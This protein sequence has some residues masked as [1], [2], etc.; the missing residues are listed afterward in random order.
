MMASTINIGIDLGTTNSLIAIA[1]EGSVEVFKNPVGH[2]ETL[3]SCVAF[4]NGRVIVGEKARELIEKDPVNVIQ[5][6][7]RKM[8]TDQRFFIEST[9][10]FVSPVELSAYVLKELKNFIYSGE[11]L[12]SAIITIPASFDTLQSNATKEAGY[13]AGIKEVVLLQEPIAASLAFVNKVADKDKLA[14]NWLV[15]DLGGGTFDAAIVEVGNEMRVLDHKGNNY[16]GGLDFDNLIIEKFVAPFL[17]LK[18]GYENVLGELKTAGSKLNRLYYILLHKAEEVK[19]ELS[20]SQSAEIEFD[21]ENS[22]GNLQTELIV[23]QR[24]EFEDLIREKIAQTIQIITDLLRNNGLAAEQIRQILLVGGSTYIPLVKKM[25]EEEAGIKVNNSIDP[26][27]AIAVGAAYFASSKIAAGGDDSVKVA[28]AA[29]NK[30][31]FEVRHSYNKHCSNAEE[32][33]VATIEGPVANH[34]Y[35]IIRNDGGF[36]TG[37]VPLK[38]KISA[39]LPLLAGN[40]NHFVFKI[41]D[42]GGDVVY[43]YPETISINQGTYSIYGQT[44]P[45]DICLEVDNINTNNTKLEIIFHKNALLPLKKTVVKTLSRTVTKGSAESVIINVFEGNRFSKPASCVALGYLRIGGEELT[46]NIYKGSDLELTFEISESRDIK[47]VAFCIS[48]TQ[49]FSNIFKPTERKINR[50]KL[51]MELTELKSRSQRE[52][53]DALSSENY[54]NADNLKRNDDEL[55]QMILELKRAPEGDVTD[56]VYQVEERKRYYSQ[57]FDEQN[58]FESAD[59]LKEEYIETRKYMEELLSERGTPRQKQQLQKIVADEAQILLS[60]SA[61]VVKAVIVDLE[62][63]IY[64]IR[65]NDPEYIIGRFMN[66]RNFPST[67]YKDYNR[68][69]KLFASGE[70]AFDERNYGELGGINQ[71]LVNNLI[72]ELLMK[73][74]YSNTGL[75]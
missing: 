31:A 71:A 75:K 14:G 43:T 28:E 22:A 58:Q 8:G 69:K 13:Q 23:I 59:Q 5:S 57:L 36:D 37:M 52:L 27:T 56:T 17:Q 60:P 53:S 64:E 7:K 20:V 1:K 16:L 34:F 26:T 42:S 38:D 48:T 19:K 47:V 2:K 73:T 6:F 70:K 74:D 49:E 21:Y 9:S 63:M 51:L 44:L 45:N 4:R 50:Q 65:S 68:A 61:H 67:S 15:Y 18:S 35:R 54:V 72:D 10:A 30:T 3:P 24:S 29:N 25:L 32:V 41:F 39:V 46:G 40:N 66:L 11:Q 33:Y 62:R 12:N 55:G